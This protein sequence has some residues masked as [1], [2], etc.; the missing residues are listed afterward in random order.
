MVD[1]HDVITLVAISSTRTFSQPL[2]RWSDNAM[3][4]PR[5]TSPAMNAGASNLHRRY[6]NGHC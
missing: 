5:L 6:R 1:Y 3:R 2:R 4:I